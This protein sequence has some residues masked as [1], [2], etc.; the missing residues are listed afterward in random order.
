[1]KHTL[2]FILTF[3]FLL[4]CIFSFAEKKTNDNLA[5]PTANISYAGTP[6]CSSDTSI[7]AVTLTGTDAYLGGVF[8]STSGLTL[9]PTT[10]EITPNTSNPGVYTVLYTIAANGSCP[11][12]NVTTLVTVLP[13]NTVTSASSFPVLC[14][15]TALVPIT[16][17][18][19]GATGMGFPTGL[20]T[21]VTAN[22]SGNIITISGTP[23]TAGVYNYSIPITGGCG[24]VNATGTIIVSSNT[25]SVASYTPTLC[26]NTYMTPITHSTTGA[27]GMGIPTGL[28]TG[29]TASWSGNTITIS[30]TSTIAGLF[31]YSIPLTGGCGTTYASGIINILMGPANTTISGGTTTCAGTPVNLTVTGTPNVVFTMTDGSNLNSYTIGASGV[32]TISVTPTITTTYTL[33]SASLNS[34]STSISG[35]E[36]SATVI[37]TPTPQFITQIPD[38]TICNGEVLNISSQLTSTIPGTTFIWSATTSNVNMSSI[39]GDQTNIDQIVDLINLSTN[40]VVTLEVVPHIGSCNGTPQQIVIIVNPIPA[41]ISTTAN[42]NT[43]CNNELVTITSNSNSATAYNWQVNTVNGVQIVGGAINGTSLSGI[44][45]VQLAL[46]NSL[47]P[48]TISFNISPVNGFC[49]GTEIINAVTITVNP[50]PS[51]PISLPS[52]NICSGEITNLTISSNPNIAGSTLE[53]IVTDSQNVSGFTNGTGLSPI[54]INDVLINS[55]NVQGFVKYSVTSKLGDCESGATNYVINVNPLPNLSVFIDGEITIDGDG[56]I[57]PYVL[58]TGLDTF[59]HNFEWYLNNTLIVGANSNSY[60]ASVEGEYSVFVTSIVTDC[61]NFANAFVAETTLINDDV[62]DLVMYPNPAFDSFSFNNIN[63]VMSV[64]ISNQMGQTVLYK[65]LNTKTGTIDLSDLNVGIY[66]IV[67]ETENGIVNQRIIKQ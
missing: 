49:Y 56:N 62:T 34:C 51:S 22:W 8:I 26:I 29:V 25:V 5:C 4:S 13:S 32:M 61:S 9:N 45:N 58:D 52:Y 39:S 19:T 11:A 1:M 44:I 15:N 65:D 38:I 7:Q 66:N 27:T 10:G 16:H 14:V 21:G 67:F 31:N 59:N 48:G 57:T 18:T 12:V 17:S 37:V 33:N 53:W 23:T 50:I 64:Q 60:T 20:P 47:V 55:S 41:I 42:Q 43:I 3:T 28:P 40:G 36:S 6:F 24:T 54:S 30:G 35:P 63:K 46:T 2:R